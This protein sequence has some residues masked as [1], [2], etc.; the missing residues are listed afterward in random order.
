[1]T[2]RLDFGGNPDLDTELGIFKEFHHCIAVLAMVK[3]PRRGIWQQSENTSGLTLADLKLN[4]LKTVLVAVCAVNVL[5][6]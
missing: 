5:Q 1:M 3:A 4:K 6:V 2:N